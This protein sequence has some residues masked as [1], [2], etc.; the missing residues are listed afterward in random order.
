MRLVAATVLLG[1]CAALAAGCGQKA[2][3]ATRSVAVSGSGPTPATTS[4]QSPIPQQELKITR[5]TG[6]VLFSSPSG[7]I[8]CWLDDE[9]GWAPVRCDVASHTWTAPTKAASNP[10]LG[11]YGSSLG[12]GPLKGIFVC[13]TDAIGRPPALPYGLGFEVGRVR[14]VSL[15]Q[16]MRCLDLQSQHGFLVS[17]ERADLF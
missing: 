13:V 8:A 2:E 10:C 14:C 1:L 12:I 7:N 11:D 5:R 15:T 17:R 16:G 4:L 3:P 9:P 6:M